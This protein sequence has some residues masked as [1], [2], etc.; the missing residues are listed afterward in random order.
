MSGNR[1]GDKPICGQCKKKLFD[2]RPVELNKSSF[3]RNLT[4]NSIPLVVDFWASWC[5]PCKMMAPA[6]AHKTVRPQTMQVAQ[7]NGDL[8]V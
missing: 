3:D 1:L 2:A 7:W 8:A 5:G 6:Y 4:H